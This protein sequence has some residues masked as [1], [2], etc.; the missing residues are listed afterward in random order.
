RSAPEPDPRGLLSLS[1][2][3]R[4]SQDGSVHPPVEE[5][6]PQSDLPADDEERQELRPAD[7][8]GTSGDPRTG[9]GTEQAVG[10]PLAEIGERPRHLTGG[11]ALVSACASAYL[12]HD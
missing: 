12:L 3:H 8:R 7:H 11:S 6:P 4:P 5:C 2:L 9:Q 1:S 10:I